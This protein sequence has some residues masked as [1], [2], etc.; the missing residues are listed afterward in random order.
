M[1]E[2]ELEAQCMKLANVID[3]EIVD[4]DPLE[5]PSFDASTLYVW[6]V[7]GPRKIDKSDRSQHTNLIRGRLGSRDDTAPTVAELASKLGIQA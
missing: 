6:L 3:T 4:G 2:Q 1:T 5:I 7:P